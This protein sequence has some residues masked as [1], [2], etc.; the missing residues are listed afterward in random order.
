MLPASVAFKPSFNFLKGAFCATLDR[1]VNISTRLLFIHRAL[2]CTHESE[3]ARN[4]TV[5]RGRTLRLTWNSHGN[6]GG[7]YTLHGRLR[8][9]K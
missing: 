1:H 4:D 2:R 5:L 7:N 6:D 3:E 9:S 8:L